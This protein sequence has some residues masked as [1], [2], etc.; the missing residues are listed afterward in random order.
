METTFNE[1]GHVIEL[2]D[3][4]R[5]LVL[6][7]WRTSP[8]S[9]SGRKVV[10]NFL[11][12]NDKHRS[13]ALE[14]WRVSQINKRE[15][16]AKAAEVRRRG[17]DIKAGQIYYD[18]WGYEQTNIDFYKIVSTTKGS[19]IVQRIGSKRV[20]GSMEGHGMSCKVE[21]DE[22]VQVG[23][24]FRMIPQFKAWMNN[25]AGGWNLKSRHGWINLHVAGD[26]HYCSW[27]A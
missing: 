15:E 23:D 19:V 4:V 20:E 13:E 7:I 2:A 25:G 14:K 9:R 17:H 11:Y 1:F 16:S 18:S 10:M 12:R 22:T 24:P 5:G 6:R 3:N 26:S 27:Y 8:R 21:P